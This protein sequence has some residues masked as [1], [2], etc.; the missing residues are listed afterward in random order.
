MRALLGVVVALSAC[1]SARRVSTHLS[2]EPMEWEIAHHVAERRQQQREDQKRWENDCLKESDAA[3]ETCRERR[4]PILMKNDVQELAGV[5][6]A[7]FHWHQFSARSWGERVIHAGDAPCDGRD[8]GL[9]PGFANLLL[10]FAPELATDRTFSELLPHCDT[11]DLPTH[12]SFA[13]DQH[14]PQDVQD[15]YEGGVRLVVSFAVSGTPLCMIAQGYDRESEVSCRDHPNIER[16][17]LAHWEFDE[18]HEWYDVALDP[19]DAYHSLR[20]DRMTALIGIESSD[21]FASAR[22]RGGILGMDRAFERRWRLRRPMDANDGDRLTQGHLPANE[23]LADLPLPERAPRSA[24][25]FR[26]I[27]RRDWI[28]AGAA[29]DH[30]M[31]RGVSTA[32]LAHEYPSEFSQSNMH[33]IALFN[34]GYQ[35]MRTFGYVERAPWWVLAAGFLTGRAGNRLSRWPIPVEERYDSGLGKHYPAIK[36]G[37][38]PGGAAFLD[39]IRGTPMIIDVGHVSQDSASQTLRF[40]RRMGR[41]QMVMHGHVPARELEWR[42]TTNYD[43]YASREV[44]QDLSMYGRSVLGYRTWIDPLK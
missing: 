37:L 36:G 17:I 8:H 7:D 32:F 14:R 33:N 27:R 44:L 42:E 28:V 24:D 26:Q 10:R 20:Q 29:R 23:I 43:Y 21:Y 11:H 35:M 22:F 4:K 3:Q 34:P 13:H 16:Q 6:I 30:L 18:Q 31:V 1:G 15:A 2:L 41:P 5:G 40:M 38:T 12:D 19:I 39:H 25:P 9:R